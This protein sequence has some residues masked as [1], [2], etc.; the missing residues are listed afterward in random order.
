[1]RIW[2]DL[3]EFSRGSTKKAI[4][5]L[6]TNPCFHLI[7]LYRLSNFLYRIHLSFL[8]KLIWYL[9]RFLFSVDID[10]RADLAGG[11]VIKHGLGIVIGMNVKSLGKLTVYQGV[12][13]GGSGK[14]RLLN[15]S[16]ITQPIIEDN[17]IIYSNAMLFGP[18]IVGK[19]QYIKAG[20]II[21]EDI[22][23][24]N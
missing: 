21:K 13:I 7:C 6:L 20:E 11:L 16:I 23:E 18:I 1:M 8:S 17:V 24:E 3:H 22:C 19:N 5:T 14:E 9:N 12:T 10:Y 2:K 4:V 15:D